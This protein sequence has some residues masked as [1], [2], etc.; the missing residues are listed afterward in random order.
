[1]L[2]RIISSNWVAIPVVVIAGAG[3]MLLYLR[4]KTLEAGIGAGL[5]VVALILIAR[6]GG[7]GPKGDV[8]G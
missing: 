7:K 1:M 8:R 2:G 5:L 3:V 6:G 4:G